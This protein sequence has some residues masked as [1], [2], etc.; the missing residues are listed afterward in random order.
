MGALKHEHSAVVIPCYGLGMTATKRKVTVSVDENALTELEATGLAGPS[1]SA[2]VNRL[3]LEDLALERQ[4]LQ[5]LEIVAEYE[6]EFGE[7]APE[8]VAHY[9]GLLA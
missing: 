7:L 4:R 8:R 6:A 5:L 9:E 1:F 3:M 2:Y